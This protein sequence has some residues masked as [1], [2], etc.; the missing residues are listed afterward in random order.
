MAHRWLAP[1][2]AA[3]LACG[4]CKSTPGDDSAI[5][6]EGGPVPGEL[7]IPFGRAPVVDGQ[8]GDAEWSGAA[9]IALDQG[10][11]LRV[12]HDGARVYLAISGAPGSGFGCVM[13]G[14]AGGVRVLH[15]SAKLGSAIYAPDR[16]GSFHPLATTYTWKEPDRLLREEGW[17]ASTMR[18]GRQQEFA[19]SFAMLG[20]PDRPARVALGFFHQTGPDPAHLAPAAP[21]TWPA[22]LQDGVGDAQLLAGFNPARLRFDMA[23]WLTPRPQPAP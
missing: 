23:S 20:L 15:A 10:A 16:D 22:G 5:L 9:S 21:I 13:V 19:L 17:V 18:D 3:V 11:T 14:G 1:A 12:L 7:S 4:A 8:V 6:S 2:A